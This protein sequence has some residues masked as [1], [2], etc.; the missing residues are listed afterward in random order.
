VTPAFLLDNLATDDY[1]LI[2]YAI[3]QLRKKRTGVSENPETASE[4]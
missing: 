1:V 4:A 3:N 2:N